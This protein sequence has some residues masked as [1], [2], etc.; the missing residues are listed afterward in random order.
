MSRTVNINDTLTLNP[1]SLDSTNSSYASVNSSYPI[2][3]GFDGS[4]SSS[5]AQFVLT[6]G[7]GA[8]T[9]VY[10]NF[11]TSEIPDGATINSVSCTAKAYVNTTS[12]RYISTREM[13]MCTGTTTKGSAT[14]ISN[15]ATA[16]TMSVGTWT[17]AELRN[18]KIRLYVTRGTSSTTST[19]YYT[20]FYGATLN[21]S[22]SLDG[23]AYTITASSTVSGVTVDPAT[24]EILEGQTATV[25]INANDISEYAITDNDVDISSQL[26][27]KQVPTGGTVTAYPGSY[28]TSGSISGTNYTGAI[29]K[30]SDAASASGND[31]CS[32][33]GSTAHIDYS[34]DFSDIP[35][36]ATIDSVAVSVKGHCES[37]SN[38][39]EVATLRLYSGSTAKG[40]ETEF[41]STSDTVVNMTTGTWTRAE[42][43]NAILRFTIGYYGGRV[44]GA[45]WTVTYSI[46]SSGNDYYYE[47]TI[48]NLDNDHVILVAEAGAFV[49][50]EE[51]EGYTYYPITISSIN[52]TTNPVNG[53]TRI[54]AGQNQTITIDPSDPRLTLA[55][56]NGVDITSQLSGHAPSNTYTID[57]QVSG[58]SYGF[59]LNSST[60]YYV[61]TNNGVNK[62]ASVARVNFDFETACVVTISYINYA[63]ASYDYGLFGKLDTE[64]ATDGLTASQNGSLPSDSTSNYELAMC[65]N[66]TSV[67]T[68][69]YNI[70]SGN[71]FVDIKYG[72]D[73]A[74]NSGDDSLQWK[75]TSVESTESYGS[76]TY[77]LNNISQSHSLIFVFGDVQYYFV[78]SSG[79]GARLYPDGQTVKLAEQNYHITIVPN[80]PEAT[81]T[82]TDNGNNVTTFLEK[83]E[84]QDK[85]GNKVVNYIYRIASVTAAHN[86]NVNC[87]GSTTAIYIKENGTW[88]K[89]TTVYK[90][91]NGVWVQQSDLST[92]FDSQN[93]Y[94]KGN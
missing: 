74:S 5:Y 44:V 20:R 51:E 23:T 1:V 32:S 45:T 71:H 73:D 47:Y 34:F 61:S 35:E 58:A 86:I 64:V 17:L 40:S 63:E 60:G 9:Y 65:S 26:V 36:N 27:Q 38:S 37:T 88:I 54:K 68:I 2:S 70:P 31:Y 87:S 52:A 79:T 75:I 84:G 76:Y 43:Q 48:T 13:Q 30:S 46:P 42:L 85:S 14:T 55:L 77:Q 62:S 6:T 56:D 83:Q 81:C 25:I 50:P 15:S 19:S 89:Y 24:Q 18:A 93:N 90:K 4:D 33:S 16:Q 53:T 22:Y 91:V 21:I 92:V 39:S 72:K 12:T 67:Q 49:P 69:T 59:Q 11:D 80:D 7:S 82:V 66:S 94:V 3:N 8:T 10:Y 78:T 29:G 28:T 57:T 41:T